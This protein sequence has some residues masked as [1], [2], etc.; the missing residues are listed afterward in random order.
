MKRLLKI[1][2]ITGSTLAPIASRRAAASTLRSTT[3]FFGGD[4]GAPALFD[5]DR[6]VRLDDQRRAGDASAERDFLAHEHLR[7]APGAVGEEPRGALWGGRGDGANGARAL[8]EPRRAA[9]RLDV[10]RLDD[11][12]LGAVDEAEARLVRVLERAAHRAERAPFDFERG[13]GA[14][15]AQLRARAQLDASARDALRLRLLSPP[16][17]RAWRRA[18]RA[19]PAPVRSRAPRRPGCGWR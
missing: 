10:D 16:R 12:R 2:S 7:V 18:A 14:G 9:G 19:A 5:D 15:V 8:G 1:S 6:L 3:W 17:R 4:F 11:Q 13:V